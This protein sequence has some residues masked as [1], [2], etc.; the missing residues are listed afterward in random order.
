M[1]ALLL[2]DTEL[3]LEACEVDEI[4]DIEAAQQAVAEVLAGEGL[5]LEYPQ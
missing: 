4:D 5:Q 2:L 1:T 3:F